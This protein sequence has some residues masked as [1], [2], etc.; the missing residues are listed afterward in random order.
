MAGVPRNWRETVSCG[1]HRRQL[2]AFGGASSGQR[3][4]Q[5]HW[6]YWAQA[7][8][9]LGEPEGLHLPP[10]LVAGLR[11]PPDGTCN[12]A[13]LLALLSAVA[14]SPSAWDLVLYTDSAYACRAFGPPSLRWL[15]HG[16]LTR[17][18]RPVANLDLL[19]LWHGLTGMRRGVGS[20]TRLYKVVS[21]SDCWENEIAD[22][23]AVQGSRLIAGA[24]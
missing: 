6:V 20:Q 14:L 15:A 4:T 18:G 5:R 8:A 3:G 10:H 1:V 12:R 2:P 13:E 21:H 19:R 7:P 23:L 22:R 24:A 11:C 17:Q 16:G 9:G